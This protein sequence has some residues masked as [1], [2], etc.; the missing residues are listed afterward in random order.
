M[1]AITVS[2]INS[3]LFVVG[4]G[5]LIGHVVLPYAPGRGPLVRLG[6]YAAVA[7][8]GGARGL[9]DA[10]LQRAAPRARWWRAAAFAAGALVLAWLGYLVVHG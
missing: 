2:R 8:I 9:R 7:A 4:G 10:T 5:M 1:K 6:F 3:A